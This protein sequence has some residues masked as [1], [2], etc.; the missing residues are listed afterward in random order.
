VAILVIDPRRSEVDR[1]DESA[2][3]S[4]IAG[5]SAAVAVVLDLRVSRN[6]AAAAPFQ[7]LA[8]PTLECV[9][10]AGVI[11]SHD[12]GSISSETMRRQVEAALRQSP[13]LDREFEQLELAAAE[14]PMDAH[15]EWKLAEFLLRQQNDRRAI[16][17]LEMIAHSASADEPLR[18]RAWVELG[19]AHLRTGEPE[20]ARHTAEALI[21]TLG[22]HD[23]Q[24]VAGGELVRGLQDTKAKRFDRA[25]QELHIAAA[26][27]PT[28]PYGQEAA[29]LLSSL[30]K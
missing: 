6:R 21:S 25:R 30:P 18:V 5:D 14:R 10:P 19:K 23:S 24:A 2:F 1:S 13:R 16:P 12:E 20:K 11:I 28:S 3:Q 9:S 4:A 26:A 17:P 15:D 29:Q 22:P 8:L 27:A 7:A